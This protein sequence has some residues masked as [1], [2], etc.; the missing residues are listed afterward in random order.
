MIGIIRDAVR[1]MGEKAEVKREID[2]MMSAKKLEFKV[3]TAIPFGMIWYMKISFPEFMDTLYGT[4][5]GVSVMTI[6]LVIYF[7][8][9][10][11][12]KRIVEIEV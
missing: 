9:Y 5:V 8:A 12:G 7:A 3:M 11:V 2:T 4:S 10:E 6:C 1:Q